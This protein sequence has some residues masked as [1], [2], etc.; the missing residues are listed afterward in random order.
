MKLSNGVYDVFKWLGLVFFPAL[1]VLISVVLPVWGVDAGLIKAL[2]VT[3]N[4]VGVFIG[5]LIG[6]SQAT[7]ARED[8]LEEFYET[9]SEDELPVEEDEPET[10]EV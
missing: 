2:V 1:A 7:I 5:A 3:I 9:V 4:A 8:A 10:E 6:V